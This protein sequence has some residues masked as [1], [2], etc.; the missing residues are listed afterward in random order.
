M[1]ASLYVMTSQGMSQPPLASTPLLLLHV[2][3]LQMQRL[4]HQVS[5]SARAVPSIQE[6][7]QAPSL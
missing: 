2:R 1:E 4:R 5:R 3:L 7:G 6:V